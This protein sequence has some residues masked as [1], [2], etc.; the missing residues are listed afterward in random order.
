LS[1]YEKTLKFKLTRE[2]VFD[3]AF[4][5]WRHLSAFLLE[6]SRS[7]REAP[8]ANDRDLQ[9]AIGRNITLINGVLLPFIK[10]DV[11]SSRYQEKNLGA[12]ILEGAQLGLLLFSQPS[13]WVWGWKA[14][15]DGAS[16]VKG[17][18]PFVIFPS[19][20]ERVEQS[21][22]QRLREVSPPVVVQL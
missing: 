19:L 16:G 20:A 1:Q 2:T 5:K 15:Q 9:A 12:I 14:P 10:A 22:R 17:G 6:P 13:V 4:T 7:T 21:G 11:A 3:K 18:R 8:K